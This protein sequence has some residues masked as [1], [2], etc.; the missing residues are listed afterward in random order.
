M[1]KRK[2]VKLNDQEV[3]HVLSLMAQGTESKQIEKETNYTRQQIAA[4]KAHVTM[5]TYCKIK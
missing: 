3:M 5:G 4:V 2:T 1:E